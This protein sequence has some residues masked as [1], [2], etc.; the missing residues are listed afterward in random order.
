MYRN[1][2]KFYV[3]YKKMVKKVASSLPKSIS[4]GKTYII[5]LLGI[6]IAIIIAG[7]YIVNMKKRKETIVSYAKDDN[8]SDSDSDS[9]DESRPRRQRKRDASCATCKVDVN[10]ENFK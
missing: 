2:P 8:G 10:M 5:I 6:F 9:D 1:Q 7:V 4:N 3:Y